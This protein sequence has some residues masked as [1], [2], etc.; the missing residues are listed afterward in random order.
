MATHLPI[1]Y[2]VSW[3]AA[4]GAGQA[5]A[6]PV[7]AAAPRPAL[8]LDEAL[9]QARVHQPSIRQAAGMRITA[10]G[11]AD[12]ARAALLPQLNGTGAYSRA[13]A[14]FVPQPSVVPRDLTQAPSPSFESF[15]YWRFGLTAS[16]LLFDFGQSPNRWRSARANAEAQVENE[17]TTAVQVAYNVRN[18]FF[19]ARAAKDMVQ[20]ATETLANQ[21]RHLS[22]VKDFVEIGTHPEIDLTQARAD[23]ANAQVQLITAENNY[24]I[25]KAQLNQSMGIEDSIDFD[26]SDETFGA[27]EGEDVGTGTLVDEAVRTRPEMG[28]LRLE[29][30]SQELA[31][32]S[33]RAD[34]WPNL[35]LTSSITDAGAV[36][37]DMG[38]NWTGGVALT[39]PI[40][41]GGGQVAQ[42]KQA[43]G[44]LVQAQA[45]LDTQRNQVRFD[46][47]QAQL[48][49]RA[50]RAAISAA[51][52]ALKNQHDR[53]GLAELRYKTGV[54]SII[55]LGDAQLANT[56]AAAQQV[57]AV[58]QLYEARALLLKA[59]GRT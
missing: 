50:A 56:A 42:V 10:E 44:A 41:A 27:V 43:Q 21:E 3:L 48:S 7:S 4:A 24:N 35:G 46:V 25:S 29:V 38:W 54:G 6:A 36:L 5:A 20:V 40:L 8:T 52:D 17:R 26:L 39:W 22:Q 9:R 13:T 33:A 11:Q 1:L 30:K 12:Q 57:Q 16:Q 59:L 53:L 14:N 19:V 18:A 28:N 45:Q 32:R 34:Y 49:V 23:R 37:T 58:Y 15:N 2:L 47:Q 31:I 55:E 51:E